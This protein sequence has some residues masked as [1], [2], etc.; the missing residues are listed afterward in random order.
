MSKKPIEKPI[1]SSSKHAII[2][3]YF[4]N[5]NV[6]KLIRS[7][8]IEDREKFTV[9][10][11]NQLYLESKNLNIIPL[12]S[13]IRWFNA[14]AHEVLLEVANFVSMCER[15]DNSLVGCPEAVAWQCH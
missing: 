11:W 5:S 10:D 9:T 2:S 6:F 14:G 3:L 1:N 12:P 7:I 15:E 8:K 4:Y 13:E